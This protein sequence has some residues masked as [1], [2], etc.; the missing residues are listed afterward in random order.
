MFRTIGAAAAACGVL[1]AAAAA[2]ACC[3]DVAPS[4]ADAA[5][6]TGRPPFRSERGAP[7]RIAY[8][9]PSASAR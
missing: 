6:A 1:F 5:I 9:T 2:A 4:A 8:P 3:S 7:I